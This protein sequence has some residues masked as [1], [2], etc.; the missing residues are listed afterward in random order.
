MTPVVLDSNVWISALLFGGN[1]RAIVELAEAGEIQAFVSIELIEEVEE[2]LRVKFRWPDSRI[3]KAAAQA[4]RAA[5]LI[6]P[7]F[8]LADC[9][10]PDDNRILECAVASSAQSI[11]TGD[12]HLLA[13][14]PY[15]GVF[16]LTPKQFLDAARRLRI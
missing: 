16:I 9:A 11:V 3:R 15:R 1:P 5:T 6:R 12:R 2:T 10:D 14:H 8:E 4:W 13:L 7:G